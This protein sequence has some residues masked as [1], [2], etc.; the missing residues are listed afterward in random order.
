MTP[1]LPVPAADGV[2]STVHRFLRTLPHVTLNDPTLVARQD[3]PP[4]ATV[5]VYANQGGGSAGAGDGLTG[6]EV[7]GIVIGS[8][9]GFL[10]LMW[11]IFRCTGGR[12]PNEPPRRDSSYYHHEEPKY[13]GNRHRSRHSHS[14]RRSG[15]IHA[16]PPVVIREYSRG[17]PRGRAHS[18]GY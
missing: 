14:R 1:H 7:A 2:R 3:S 10:L 17:P 6:G 15:S 16:P 12:A 18:R 4:Q 9:V 13:H 8:I 5:T 11:F